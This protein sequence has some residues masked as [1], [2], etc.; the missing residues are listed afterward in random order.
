LPQKDND[1]RAV[2]RGKELFFGK[3]NCKSCHRGEALTSIDP[4]AVIPDKDGNLTPFD[5]PSLRGVARTAPYLHDGRA[6]TLE[7]IFLKHNPKQRHGRAHELSQPEVRDLVAFL[8][9]L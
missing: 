1:P 6:A 4:R 9:S 2:A 8:K 5:V 7:D 3:G